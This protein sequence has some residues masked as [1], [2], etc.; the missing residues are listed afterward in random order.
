MNHRDVA[1]TIGQAAADAIAGKLGTQVELGKAASCDTDE[2]IIGRPLPL[3]A[4]VVNFGRPLRDVLVIVSSLKEDAVRPLA[5]AA[6]RA[7]GEALGVTTGF[8]DNGVIGEITIDDAVEFETVE[9]ALE[10]CDALYLE[11]HYSVELPHGELQLVLGTGLLEAATALVNGVAES[12]EANDEPGMGSLREEPRLEVDTATAGTATDQLNVAMAH[13]HVPDAELET[14]EPTYAGAQSLDTF[15]AMLAEQETTATAIATANAA[16]AADDH[17]A[18][19]QHLQSSR[20]WTQLLSGVEVE[21]SAELGR[22]DLALRD[23]TNLS[24]N[25]VLTLDQLVDEP[26]NVYVNGTPY[27]TA[28]LVVVDGEYGIEILEVVDQAGLVSTIAA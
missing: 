12:D 11:A 7:V 8:D 25:S 18:T 2:M 5:E 6:G 28:R 26:V 21:L 27:A 22:A 4:I 1:E 16:G 24:A 17:G 19:M 20:R 10:Q 23:I 3:R 9:D 14:A 13:G 15:D